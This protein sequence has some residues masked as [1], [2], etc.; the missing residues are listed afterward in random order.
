MTEPQST[1]PGVDPALVLHLAEGAPVSAAG[2]AVRA[3]AE[4]AGVAAE[5]ATQL[6]VLIEQLLNE[7]F[8]RRVQ[9]EVARRIRLAATA[10]D[11]PHA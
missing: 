11:T 5:R 7:A 3:V 2:G 10:V 8:E 9:S 6:R 1:D 4:G